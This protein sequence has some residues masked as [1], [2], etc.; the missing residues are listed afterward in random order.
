MNEVIRDPA[1]AQAKKASLELRVIPVRMV[2]QVPLDLMVP[3]VIRD[4][5]DRTASRDLKAHQVKRDSLVRPVHPVIPVKLANPVLLE[6]KVQKAT[7]DPLVIE[8][9]VM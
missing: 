7:R 5:Q 9:V 4:P 2:H 3:K 6:N 8:V 1:V